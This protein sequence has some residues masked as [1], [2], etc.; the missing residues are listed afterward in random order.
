[1]DTVAELMGHIS[2]KI[3]ANDYDQSAKN[4]RIMAEIFR[5]VSIIFML[6]I[7]IVIG[8][9]FWDTTADSFNWETS[10]FRVVLSLMLSAPAAYCAREAAKHREQYYYYLQTSISMK[11]LDPYIGTLPIEDQHALKRDMAKSL[12]AQRDFSHV[13]KD[14]FPIN[15]H[16]IVMEIL[17]KLEMPKGQSSSRDK[18]KEEADA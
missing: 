18:K 16:E 5:C 1:M 2:K 9:T 10:I 17:K 6:V 7:A 11:A 15:S 4:E 14:A 8:F 12:F 13:S 3:V